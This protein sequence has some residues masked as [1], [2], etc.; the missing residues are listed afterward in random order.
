MFLL[1]YL[2]LQFPVAY[3]PYVLRVASPEMRAGKWGGT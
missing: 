2:P 3:I 1:L